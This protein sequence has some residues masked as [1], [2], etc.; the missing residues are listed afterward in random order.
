M[1]ETRGIL[2]TVLRDRIVCRPTTTADGAA[3]YQLTLPIAFDR[4]L[5]T[6]V[7]ALQVGGT[8]PR[9]VQ[10]V[11]SKWAPATMVTGIAA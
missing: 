8:S 4:L 10:D 9:G 6:I 11:R 1:T 2:E 5:T 7:P 3:A